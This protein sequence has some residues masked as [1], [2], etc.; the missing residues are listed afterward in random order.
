[1]SQ[2]GGAIWIALRQPYAPPAGN[3]IAV[4]MG[5]VVP[6]EPPEPPPPPFRGIVASVGMRYGARPQRAASLVLA[7]VQ[8]DRLQAR[9]I[10]AWGGQ[11]APVRELARIVWEQRQPLRA[12][13]RVRWSAA[14]PAVDQQA[15]LVWQA[16]PAVLRGIDAPWA[17]APQQAAHVR[18][19]WLAPDRLDLSALLPWAE[20]APL[21]R[22]AVIPWLAPPRKREQARLPWGEAGFPEWRERPEPIPPRPEPP[23]PVFVP[24]PGN[25]IAI[26]L[27]CRRADIPGNA[28]RVPFGPWA[29]FAARRRERVIHV[30]NT[31]SI[32]RLPAREPI[33]CTGGSIETSL[34]GYCWGVELDGLSEAALELCKPAPDGTRRRLEV[35]VNGHTFVVEVDSY[36]VRN[37]WPG[38]VR[39]L[40]GRSVTSM[41]GAPES[42]ASSRTVSVARSAAQ[43]MQIELD[44]I[45]DQPISLDFPSSLDWTVPG[46]A[47]SYTDMTPIEA[48]VRIAQA[49]GY[50]IQSDPALPILRV[51]KVYPVPAW[52]WG[53]TAPD[54]DITD[55]LAVGRSDESARGL[56]DDSIIV[57]GDRIGVQ[58]QAT[59]T[60]EAGVRQAPAVVDPLITDV[61]KAARHRAEYEISA[62]WPIGPRTIEMPLRAPE[63]APGLLAPPKLVRINGGDMALVVSCRITW[64][65]SGQQLQ[66]RQIVTTGGNTQAN[67]WTRFQSLLPRS[68]LIMASVVAHN[69]DGTSTLQTIDGST[70]RAKG[71]GVPVGQ[72]AEV[73]G[74][75]VLRAAALLPVSAIN[76]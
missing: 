13:Q 24:Q 2:T 17:D 5:P 33:A 1:M 4:P 61:Q 50:S 20:G 39:S 37:G 63:I 59:I 68:R 60:G 23:P 67:V 3:A 46:G 56:P 19:R 57:R 21:R 41:L 31:V 71:Q 12:V 66:V 18:H 48:L 7:W 22:Q 11:P 35:T 15:R 47:W 16:P 42:A 52:L 8:R 45:D 6:P 29:C 32:V 25:T 74:G 34:S 36:A 51:R 27:A 10:A 28:L 9:R 14:P 69:A 55:S 49:A 73:Q 40:R 62:R 43:L 65:M 72:L 70:I 30:I 64:R 38:A 26:P 44:A 53:V 54:Q 58:V 75:E 76:L